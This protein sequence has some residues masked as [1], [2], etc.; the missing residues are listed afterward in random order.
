MHVHGTGHTHTHT[1][2]EHIS[3]LQILSKHQHAFLVLSLTFSS[4]AHA[5]IYMVMRTHPHH[6]LPH[7]ERSLDYKTRAK[8]KRQLI[9]QWSPSWYTSVRPI[10]QY[11]KYEVER[12]QDIEL[13]EK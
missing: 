7:Q 5:H 12:W 2:V 10:E 11:Q 9:K 3:N 1:P 4:L 6:Q 8:R 13:E